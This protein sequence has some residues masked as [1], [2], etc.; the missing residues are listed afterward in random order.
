MSALT[1]PPRSNLA[2][3][4]ALL[5]EMQL[6]AR[7]LPQ[8]TVALDRAD[9]A[10]QTYGERYAEGLVMLLHAQLK[11]ARGEPLSAVRDAAE[12]AQ[13]L[14]E[15]SRSAPLRPACRSAARQSE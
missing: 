11:Q 3:W 14:F 7:L 1:D 6:W 9:A 2:T 4:L 8:A 13:I 5:A 15:S 10:L 12:R